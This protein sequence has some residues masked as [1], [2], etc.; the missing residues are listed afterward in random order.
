MRGSLL[1][2]VLHRKRPGLVPLFDSKAQMFYQHEYSASRLG[3]TK[4]PKNE[5]ILEPAAD[6]YLPDFVKLA[7]SYGHVGIRIDKPADVE[8]ALKEAFKRTEELVFMDFITDQTENV[9]P[10]IPAGKGLD[11]MILV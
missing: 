10:M 6:V 1:A 3:Q 11:E 5:K 7:E 8:P 4:R 9:F 2:K